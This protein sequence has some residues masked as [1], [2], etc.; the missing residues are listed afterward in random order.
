[1]TS[2]AGASARKMTNYRGREA[3]ENKVNVFFRRARRFTL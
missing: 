3:R 2:V 1:L